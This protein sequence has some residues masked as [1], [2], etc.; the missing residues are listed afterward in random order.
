MSRFLAGC[1]QESRAPVEVKGLY[2]FP[3]AR[4]RAPNDG[5]H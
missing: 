3:A 2:P 4:L 1:G 5:K